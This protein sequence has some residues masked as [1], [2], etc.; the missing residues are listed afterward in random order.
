MR[1]LGPSGEDEMVA[2][3]L[4]GELSSERFGGAIR[5]ALT[6]AGHSDRLVLDPDLSDAVGNEAR[7]AVLAATRGY[8]ED[9]DVF[10][11]FPP[12]VRWEWVELTAEEPAATSSTPTGMSSPAGAVW[13]PM[14][15]SGSEPE[16]ESS[17][18]RT[19][20]SSARPPPSLTESSSLL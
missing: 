10:E 7:R 17:T 11:D 5:S 14:R 9:R 20:V 8:G 6:A 18:C 4:R 12:G 13:R 16:K 3:F 19:I 15:R 1:A 2:C